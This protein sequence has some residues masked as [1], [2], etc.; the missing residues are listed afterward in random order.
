[1]QQC[2]NSGFKNLLR[3]FFAALIARASRFQNCTKCARSN[4]FTFVSNSLNIENKLS[5][6]HQRKLEV[7]IPQPSCMKECEQTM[8]F[9][10]PSTPAT[11]LYRVPVQEGLETQS[12][13]RYCCNLCFI[14]WLFYCN[15]TRKIDTYH[16]LCRKL[17]DT[18][19]T[20]SDEL[21]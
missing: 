6:P 21:V 19:L 12:R 18:Y 9:N 16:R 8:H 3:R 7:V 2:L 1:M 10:T 15:S 4:A 14:V 17:V 11:T 20:L 13:C 5:L